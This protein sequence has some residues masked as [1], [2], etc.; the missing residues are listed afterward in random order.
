MRHREVQS[1]WDALSSTPVTVGRWRVHPLTATS[2]EGRRLHLATGEPWFLSLLVPIN[3]AIGVETD[4]RSRGVIVRPLPAG[5]TDLPYGPYLRIDCVDPALLDVFLPLCTDI[6]SRLDASSENEGDAIVRSTLEDWRLLLAAK[7]ASLPV[8][9]AM[10]LIGEFE[11]LK[12]MAGR[13]GE[14][15]AAWGGP[16]KERH[17][18]ALPDGSIEVKASSAPEGWRIHISSI[19]Q[20][21]PSTDRP[22]HLVAVE[23]RPDRQ[24]PS[25]DERFEE[26]VTLGF[27]R[28]KLEELVREVGYIPGAAPDAH[29]FSVG[30]VRGWHVSNDFPGPRRDDLPPARMMGVDHLN[31]QL[32]LQ[33]ISGE[34][35]TLAQVLDA[36]AWSA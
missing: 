8:E 5:A 20:L 26:L 13:P 7:S 32:D 33:H 1:A 27:F 10:G 14:A 21:T 17:D 36:S 22:L 24:G 29:R 34:A 18:F 12:S 6:A 35:I 16:L 28:S 23:T 15:L 4:E 30:K 2:A 9:Q 25:L 11:V 3:S 31:Y 19:D